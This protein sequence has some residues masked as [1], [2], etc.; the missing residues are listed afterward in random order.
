M[1]RG[2]SEVQDSGGRT[3]SGLFFLQKFLTFLE[4]SKLNHTHS[5]PSFQWLGLASL[6]LINHLFFHFAAEKVWNFPISQ[7]VPRA[8]KIRQVASAEVA[9]LQRPDDPKEDPRRPR[10]IHWHRRAAR[11]TARRTFHSTA[12]D[13]QV[14]S[15]PFAKAQVG[16]WPC[17]L[18]GFEA[19]KSPLL[20]VVCG[21]LKGLTFAN[22]VQD[23]VE[24]SIEDTEA[25]S[26]TQGFVNR[27][28]DDRPW[29]SNKIQNMPQWWC[30]SH[31]PAWSQPL[32]SHHLSNASGDVMGMSGCLR[33]V[34]FWDTSIR[35]SIDIWNLTG[36]AGPKQT[37]T[38]MHRYAQD[39]PDI[40]SSQTTNVCSHLQ[41]DA[42]STQLMVAT[43]PTIPTSK[44]LGM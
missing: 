17:K 40:L 28:A 38:D 5:H 37:C 27:M 42:L 11:C 35:V 26:G 3:A 30:P 14:K 10:W 7:G 22:K 15:Q 18:I 1:G 12:L 21:R 16:K 36:Q 20:C 32:G 6:Q 2:S 4:V 23:E 41:Q 43:K 34:P 39:I 33:G 44:T 29:W 25:T 24:N 9:S 19:W 8:K 13:A 31:P